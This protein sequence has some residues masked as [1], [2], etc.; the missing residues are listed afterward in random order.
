[1]QEKEEDTRVDTPKV[2]TGDNPT[3]ASDEPPP[4]KDYQSDLLAMVIDLRYCQCLD[5]PAQRLCGQCHRAYEVVRRFIWCR[6]AS[7]G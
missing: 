5:R 7:R 4:E 6:D 1:M 2:T 3:A